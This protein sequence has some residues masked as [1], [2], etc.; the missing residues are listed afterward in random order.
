MDSLAD[1]RLDGVK[2]DGRS[3][4]IHLGTPAKMIVA[5]HAAYSERAREL[6]QQGLAW[7]EPSSV[8]V[9]SSASRVRFAGLRPPYSKFNRA[10]L[11][12]SLELVVQ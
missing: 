8:M 4:D 3:N 1:S 6:A 12:R 9:N 7:P 5:P 10:Q 11:E 2:Q